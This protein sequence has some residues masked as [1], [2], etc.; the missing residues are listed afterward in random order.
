[1]AFEHS[2]YNDIFE[3]KIINVQILKKF[4]LYTHFFCT[5][6]EINLLLNSLEALSIICLHTLWRMQGKN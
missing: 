5:V 6:Y 1:M 2:V 4:I 3:N